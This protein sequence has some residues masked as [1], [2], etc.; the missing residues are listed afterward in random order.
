M[1]TYTL[2][3]Q[4]HSYLQTRKLLYKF[5]ISICYSSVY[6]MDG[7][8]VGGDFHM[9]S[10]YDTPVIDAGTNLLKVAP[11]TTISV[12]PGGMTLSTQT[13]LYIISSKATQLVVGS[14]DG[15]LNNPLTIKAAITAPTAPQGI[16]STGLNPGG[17][18]RING[19]STPA[20]TGGSLPGFQAAF[21]LPAP[22]WG[23][24]NPW[25]IIAP[26]NAPT[27]AFR[28]DTGALGWADGI[29]PNDG[30]ITSAIVID[31]TSLTAL[32]AATNTATSLA[33][34]GIVNGGGPTG[35]GSLTSHV[36]A[37]N[38]VTSL[39][40][41]GIVNG[42]S[43]GGRWNIG[44]TSCGISD[45]SVPGSSLQ[46]LLAATNGGQLVVANGAVIGGSGAAI[47]N[48]A[49]NATAIDAALL[50]SPTGV[51]SADLATLAGEVVTTPSG[52]LETDI[53]A[54]NSALDGI[55][56]GSTVQ[57]RISDVAGIV[58][59]TASVLYDN[60]AAANTDLG[61]FG[62][63]IARI[64]SPLL[65]GSAS[66]LA[67]VIGGTGTNLAAQLGDPGTGNTL[68]GNIGGSTT[69]VQAALSDVAGIV[70]GTA[71]VLYDN[72]AAAN[73]ALGGSGT[74]T[75]TAR[76][77][78]LGSATSL[79]A[80]IGVSGSASLAAALDNTNSGNS[81]IAAFLGSSTTPL[82]SSIVGSSG[83]LHQ[84]DGTTL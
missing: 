15:S 32:V 58:G 82:Y 66:S 28:T 41:K 29:A 79:S 84:I 74:T 11:P 14:S 80:M 44:V 83:I 35:K 3:M 17:V 72:V 18:I 7:V 25:V 73:T 20:T 19:I 47:S 50:Q 62:T 45:F 61:G 49:T 43:T 27:Y 22:I 36:A 51:V 23:I 55:A 4:R 26:T 37:T 71:S 76:I 64:G 31:P 12:G 30:S 68:I 42:G 78:N 57:A 65:G 75:T 77:G 40:T 63:T 24:N 10:V 5:L 9:G 56:A 60:V 38:A 34:T 2:K 53:Q 39:T 46:A 13:L 59:G 16:L 8:A 6:G 21:G 48:A 54:I 81:S 33:T 52:V 67:A 1:K 70:G 69:S